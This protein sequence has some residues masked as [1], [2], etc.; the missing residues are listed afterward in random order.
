[1][2]RSTR[3]R[4]CP[5]GCKVRLCDLKPGT[6]FEFDGCVALK[7]EYTAGN[8][9]IEAYIVGSGELFWGGAKCVEEQRELMVQPLAGA[10]VEDTNERM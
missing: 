7:S 1:M 9:L 10:A 8:G 4:L 3:T 6:L 2:E 5:K